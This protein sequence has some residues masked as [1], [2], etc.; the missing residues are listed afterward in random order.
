MND[1]SIK[2]FIGNIQAAG[3]GLTL[4]AASNVLFVEL[5][6]TPKDHGQAEDRAHRIG[7]EESVTAWYMLGKNTIDERIYEMINAKKKIIKKAVGDTTDA[8]VYNERIFNTKESIL[9]G[10]IESYSK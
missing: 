1:D 8:E 3:V 4:T 9:S 10:L 5:G 2:L 7:Q 6:W